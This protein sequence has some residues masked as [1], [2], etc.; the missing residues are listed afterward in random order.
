M[1]A[2]LAIV[3][4]T[5]VTAKV[6]HRW[7]IQQR[8]FEKTEI[9]YWLKYGQTNINDEIVTVSQWVTSIYDQYNKE[10]I[11]RAYYLRDNSIKHVKGQVTTG[12]Y[13][14]YLPY[15]GEKKCSTGSK[16]DVS[17][18][19]VPHWGHVKMKWAD[20]DNFTMTLLDCTKS[21]WATVDGKKEPPLKKD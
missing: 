3:G 5:S 10:V 6:Q 16:E 7:V 2:I 8:G 1:A 18:T 4:T 17:F 15:E 11:D 13:Y 19:R 12:I 9:M 21:R 20:D 14:S